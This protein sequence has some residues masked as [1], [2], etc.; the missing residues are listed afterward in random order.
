MIRHV[1]PPQ[2]RRSQA[3]YNFVPLPNAVLWAPA[4]A[5]SAAEHFDQFIEDAHSGYIDLEITAKTPLYIRGPARKQD[6]AW[7]SREVRF[8]LEPYLD[9][10]GRPVIPGSSLRGA[11]RDSAGDE[12]KAVLSVSLPRPLGPC[13]SKPNV[14][15]K[16]CN[17]ITTRGLHR[18]EL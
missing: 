7:D 9:P 13:L 4:C 10:Q 15:A 6:D 17:A 14:P 11:I 2:N 3:P 18:E 12:R 5:R 16:L 8:R 1:N